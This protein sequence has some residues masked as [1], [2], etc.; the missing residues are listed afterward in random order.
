[1][2]QGSNQ[3]SV[4]QLASVFGCSS[5]PRGAINQVYVS[6]VQFLQIDSFYGYFTLLEVSNVM[7]S[8]LFGLLK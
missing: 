3:D 1:M 6:F 8:I 4:A 5:P 7:E 2:G